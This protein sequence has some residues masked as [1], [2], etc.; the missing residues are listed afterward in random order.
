MQ[1][2]HS[3]LQ[4]HIRTCMT[5]Q[6]DPTRTPYE[7][8]VAIF[9]QQVAPGKP[10]DYP[11]SDDRPHRSP[12]H[13]NLAPPHAIHGGLRR[14]PRFVCQTPLNP[15]PGG[16]HRPQDDN[17]LTLND[18]FYAPP[19]STDPP[20]ATPPAAPRAP[21][22]LQARRQQRTAPTPSELL[23]EP[24]PAPWAATIRHLNQQGPRA[25][26]QPSALSSPVT[27]TCTPAPSL[28]PCFLCNAPDHG[29]RACPSYLRACQHDPT[30]ASKCPA[31]RAPGFCPV[32]CPRRQYF[33]RSTRF[34]YLEVDRFGH[35]YYIRADLLSPAWFHPGLLR[36]V[37]AHERPTPQAPQQPSVALLQLHPGAADAAPPTPATTAPRPTTSPPADAPAAHRAVFCAAPAAPSGPPA[38]PAICNHTRL[39]TPLPTPN[40]P[41]HT[42]AW[43][44]IDG[45][46]CEVIMDTGAD[47]SLISANVFRPHRSYQ[48]WAPAHGSVSG[49]NNHTL[50][51]LGRVALEVRLGPLRATAPFFMV[52]GVAFAALLGVDLLNAHEIAVSLARH[53]LIFEG[54]GGQI[55]PL[56]GHHPRLAPL[57]ALEQD[58]AMNPGKIAWV[59]TTLPPPATAPA[60]PLVY[61]VAASTLPS[62]G[63]AIPEQLTS[64]LFVIR[65]TSDR[66]LHLSAS[67]PLAKA[68]QLPPAAVHTVRLVATDPAPPPADGTGD[69]P[70]YEKVPGGFLPTLPSP[71]SCLLPAELQQL[72]DLLHEFRDRSNDGSGPLSATSLLKARL[73]TAATSRT[74][75]ILASFNGKKYFSVLDMLKGYYQIEI[76]EEDRPK[77]SFVTPD[78]QR[79]YRRLPFGFASSPAI[80]QRM[81]DLFLGGMKWVSAVGYIDDIIVYTATWDAHR[82]HLRQLFQALRDA[83]LQ[84]HPGKCSFGAA[85]AQPIFQQDYPLSESRLMKVHYVPRTWTLLMD[86]SQLFLQQ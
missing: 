77:T 35:S 85:V 7:H 23:Q 12:H 29:H 30:P 84:L 21:A 26:T 63:L 74:D 78:C 24:P 17:T 59:R 5:A 76:A 71:N 18:D 61:L 51:V 2:L 36:A 9:I 38:P 53:A 62:V 8:M 32:S 33:S 86:L 55:F 37:L 64:G 42:R 31:C 75:D 82:A 67:W 41:T 16:E 15:A 1:Q 72:R 14:V 70:A 11:A 83:N 45:A 60:S 6:P 80:F 25:P 44:T 27:M 57:C 47:L 10:E 58:V 54:H 68:V 69:K 79:Q 20:S 65:N 43:A 22:T 66:P 34:P 3:R 19:A 13:A 28:A 40:T 46:R 52:S 73:D 50:Q 56:L 48:P 49:V 39:G 4:A 81:V